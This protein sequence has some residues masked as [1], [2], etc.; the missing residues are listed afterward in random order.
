MFFE[1]GMKRF[2]VLLM[3]I[4]FLIVSCEKKDDAEGIHV[5]TDRREYTLFDTIGI[6]IR[7]NYHDS[8]LLNHEHC[9]FMQNSWTIVRIDRY[10]NDS[11]WIQE[12]VWHI[13]PLI[14]FPGAYW[15]GIAPGQTIKYGELFNM[16]GKF[17]LQFRF[18]IDG[19]TTYL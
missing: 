7:N 11:S 3:L 2:D 14:G 17:H 8:I 10:E 9:G 15:T 4:I 1:S 19:D 12:D 13:C 6:T 5:R 18:M 16:T